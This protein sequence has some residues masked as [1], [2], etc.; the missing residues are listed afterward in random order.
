MH[1]FFYLVHRHCTPFRVLAG[2]SLALWCVLIGLTW[3]AVRALEA[4]Q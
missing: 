2:F 4:C 1:Y 3:W